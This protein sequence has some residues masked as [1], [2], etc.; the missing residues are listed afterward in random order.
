MNA[1]CSACHWVVSRVITDGDK[2]AALPKN[3]VRAGAKS[4]VDRPCRYNSGRTSLTLGLLRHHGGT[5]A[6]LNCARSPVSESTR[7]SLTRGAWISIAPA[8][9]VIV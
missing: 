8:A 1:R 4:P 3:S 7:R 9:V 2:P 6:D 5:I